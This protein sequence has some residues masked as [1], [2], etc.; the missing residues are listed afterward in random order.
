MGVVAGSVGSWYAAAAVGFLGRRPKLRQPG[1]ALGAICACAT[2]AAWLGVAAVA[3]R[4]ASLDA[5][6]DDLSGGLLP[7]AQRMLD[8]TEFSAGLDALEF[9]RWVVIAMTPVAAA[10]GVA[11]LCLNVWLAARVCVISGLLPGGWPDIQMGGPGFCFPVWRWNGSAYA[12]NR[13]E[14]EGKRCKPSSP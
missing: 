6:L 9:T 5:A 13:F 14:Y 12:L 8:S 4:Y 10:W 2:V 3:F 7:F 1:Y 11:A